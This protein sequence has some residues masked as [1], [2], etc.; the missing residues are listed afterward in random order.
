MQINSQ[1]HGKIVHENTV[2]FNLSIVS[3]FNCNIRYPVVTR[4]PCNYK[5]ANVCYFE[6]YILQFKKTILY[7]I[8]PV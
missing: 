8:A 4:D 2:I 1:S 3:D 5:K 6:A 7:K